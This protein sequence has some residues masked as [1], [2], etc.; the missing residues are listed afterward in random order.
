MCKKIVECANLTVDQSR[1]R[2]GHYR[3]Y[4]PV[5]P[6]QRPSTKTQYNSL[7]LA[8]HTKCRTNLC[9][10]FSRGARRGAWA[11]AAAMPAATAE[12]L[13]YWDA[14][15]QRHYYFHVSSQETAWELPE[16][17]AFQDGDEESEEMATGPPSR[18]CA[19]ALPCPAMLHGAA[20]C[21]SAGST[22]RSP[23]DPARCP[24]ALTDAYTPIS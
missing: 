11:V 15:V 10:E 4:G 2:I 22:P 16:G 14:N 23:R 12:W 8:P 9:S 24:R 5:D 21:A 20:A 13:R 6:V 17:S 19:L 18:P 7:R 3:I 1:S